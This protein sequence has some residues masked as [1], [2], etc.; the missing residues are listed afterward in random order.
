MADRLEM[1]DAMIAKGTDDPFVF[2]ARA[3]EFR[4]RGDRA[5]ALEAFTDVRDRFEDYV[6]TYLM[7]A[8]VCA[9]QEDLESARTWCNAGIERAKA[10]GDGHAEGEL[11]AFLDELA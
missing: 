3:M 4:S 2:Y 1:L 11:Q 6:P 9:E 7:A 5:A 10:A 8:Q